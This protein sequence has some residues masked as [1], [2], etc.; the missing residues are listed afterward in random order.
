MTQSPEN[1]P[2]TPAPSQ[3]RL[4]NMSLFLASPF[5]GLYYAV[6]LPGKLIQLA[7]AD[8]QAAATSPKST[9]KS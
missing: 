5:I 8:L 4:K 6:V 9:P 7:R 2:A 3:S 1:Q